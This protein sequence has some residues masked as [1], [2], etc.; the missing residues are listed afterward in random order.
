MVNEV[1]PVDDN[2]AWPKNGSFFRK[3][4]NRIS[5]PLPT[6][7]NETPASLDGS[8]SSPRQGQQETM[9]YSDTISVEI[10]MQK[11]QLCGRSS[12]DPVECV[13][14]TRIPLMHY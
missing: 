5:T 11:P 2:Y 14:K 9:P 1:V 8:A 4:T 10:C 7:D 13:F 6:A 3:F 12:L